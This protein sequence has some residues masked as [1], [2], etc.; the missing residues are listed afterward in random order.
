MLHVLFV[1]IVPAV[2]RMQMSKLLL[3]CH[4]GAHYTK[5]ALVFTFLSLTSLLFV[6]LTCNLTK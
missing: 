5:N 4:Q 1:P 6:N 3:L 2:L